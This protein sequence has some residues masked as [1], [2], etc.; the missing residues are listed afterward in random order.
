MPTLNGLADVVQ[1]VRYSCTGTD[2][3]TEASIDGQVRLTE[4]DPNSFI[5]FGSLTFQNI[6]TWVKAVLGANGITSV[7]ACIQGQINSIV[8]PPASPVT[9]QFPF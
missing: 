6:D 8:S 5:A 7:E 1:T 4:P 9:R 3:G 2:N